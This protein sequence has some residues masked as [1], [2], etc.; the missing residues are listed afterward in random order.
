MIRIISLIILISLL[1]FSC[2]LPKNNVYIKTFK[3]NKQAYIGIV[4]LL[5]SNKEALLNSECNLHTKGSLAIIQSDNVNEKSCY[6]E[7][8]STFN[9]YLDL[10]Y[11]QLIQFYNNDDIE[12]LV[13]FEPARTIIG[14]ETNKYLLYTAKDYL[15][16]PYSTWKIQR[17]IDENWW[18]LEDIDAD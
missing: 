16:L 15:S 11:F 4:T 5:K 13:E 6:P 3:D 17:K 9:K 10:K 1:Q 12:F 18:Y 2:R 14:T 8:A 7:I